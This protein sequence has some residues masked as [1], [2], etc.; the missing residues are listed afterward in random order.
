M[1]HPLASLRPRFRAL[2]PARAR[3]RLAGR[4]G[5]TL[6]EMMIVAGLIV[7]LSALAIGT[8]IDTIGRF[9]TRRAAHELANSVQLARAYAMHQMRETR[10][11]IDEV[12]P[13]ALY[14]QYPNKGKWAVE[15]GNRSLGSTIWTRLKETEIDISAV[16]NLYLRH[17]SLDYVPGTLVGP[18][19]CSCTDAIVFAPNGQVRNPSTDFDSTNGDIE[20]KFVNKAT[21]PDTV[22]EWVVRIYRGGMVRVESL[23]VDTY[24]EDQG[25]TQE[26][27]T[28]A[29]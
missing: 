2:L 12:D 21:L 24:E 29:G 9:R 23:L 1:I 25:G 20:I 13:N 22:D 18:A 10:V 6:L 11:V 17:A 16:G 19:D 26:V 4:R 15:L 7:I 14:P 8:A 27:S 3:R 5:F 28:Y